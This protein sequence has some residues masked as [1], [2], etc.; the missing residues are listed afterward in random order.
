MKSKSFLLASL[1]LSVATLG[2][3]YW[4]GRHSAR[5]S[6]YPD[7]QSVVS[8]AIVSPGKEILPQVPERTLETS[9]TSPTGF[10]DP[11]L[12]FEES[13]TRLRELIASGDL[14]RSG[15]WWRLI[16]LVA[17]GDVPRL[18]PLVEQAAS[19][20][21]RNQLRSGLIG[22]WAEGDPASAMAYANNIADKVARESA[23][24]AALN[25]WAQ[26][27]LQSAVAWV[28]KLPQGQLRLRA[29]DALMYR[30]AEKDPQAAL[31]FWQSSGKSS[32]NRGALYPIFR[33]WTESDPN[34]AVARA[35]ELTSPLDRSQAYQ[36]I[37]SQWAQK[38][39]D[40]KSVV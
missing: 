24:Q 2:L 32:R 13:E 22:R 34:T 16:A 20:S 8:S 39:P 40:R 27:D 23:I 21:M 7:G 35:T 11:V 29:M 33:A 17:P 37:A 5:S 3:G 25:G 36:A 9:S 15:N 31:D 28:Q 6:A 19:A 14:S 38:D 18:L 30:M 1:I 26:S 12:P 10:A 4:W